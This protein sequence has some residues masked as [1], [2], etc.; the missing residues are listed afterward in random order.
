MTMAVVISVDQHQQARCLLQ[1]RLPQRREPSPTGEQP[2][3]AE[4]AVVG[5]VRACGEAAPQIYV[6]ALQVRAL[7]KVVLLPAAAVLGYMTL[8]A[9]GIRGFS[10]CCPADSLMSETCPP[11][12]RPCLDCLVGQAGTGLRF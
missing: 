2:Q 6:F 12:D 8:P 10:T 4:G 7:V 5:Y 11:T 3:A 1:K 9:L